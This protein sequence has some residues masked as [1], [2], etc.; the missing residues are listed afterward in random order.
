MTRDDGEECQCRSC[1]VRRRDQMI[2]AVA[3]IQRGGRAVYPGDYIGALFGVHRSYVSTLARRAGI[4]R[5]KSGRMA[6]R[7]GR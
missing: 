6:L 5:D 1:V 7:R 2:V 4:T 3:S